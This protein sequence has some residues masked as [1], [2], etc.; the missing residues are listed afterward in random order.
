MGV[1]RIETLSSLCERGSVRLAEPA[2]L[3]QAIRDLLESNSRHELPADET[4]EFLEKWLERLN[5]ASDGRPMFVAPFA[6]VER[7]MLQP[8]WPNQLRDAL[9]L[10]HVRPTGGNPVPVVL[11]Q[12]SLERS[13][14][15]H[16]AS[17][18]WAATPTVLDDPA[19]SGLSTCFFPAPRKS[20]P[21]EFGF[22]V[23]LSRSGTSTS[24]FLHAHVGYT[25]ADIR[26]IGDVTTEVT[27]D[28]IAAARRDHLERLRP[29]F[30]FH[31]DLPARS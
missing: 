5:G 11:F 27:D 13:Y 6:A 31:T 1:V 23:D 22:T 14:D 20:A 26:D 15:A 29:Q 18:A 7:Q 24:E 28:T 30:R 19:T 17:P 10:G 8:D 9:G 12:Y 25:L 4:L 3:S 21:P 16:R 2:E